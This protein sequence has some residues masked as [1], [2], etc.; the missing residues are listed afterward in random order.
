MSL[1]PSL[2]THPDVIHKKV[3]T[4]PDML[5]M[6]VQ[7]YPDH[8]AVS[9][10][11][12]DISYHCLWQEIEKLAA[13][14]QR[15]GVGK[16]TKIAIMLPNCPAYLRFYFATLLLGG[17]VINLNPLYTAH[18]IAEHISLVE[19]DHI[20]T[21]DLNKLVEK[22]LPLRGRHNVKKIFVAS[23]ADDLPFIKKWGFKATQFRQ[24][25]HQTERD[26]VRYADLV[27]D[28]PDKPIDV[29]PIDPYQDVAV[30][31]LTGGTTGR[32]KASMLTHHNLVSNA[33]QCKA[34]FHGAE[35]GKESF[36]AVIPFFH[37]FAL[38]AILHL[39]ISIGATLIPLPRFEL[40]QLLRTIHKTRPTIFQAVPTIY[41]AINNAKKLENYD[42][43]SIKLCVSGGAPLPLEVRQ[44]FERITGCKLVE[45]YGLTECSPVACCNPTDGRAV[46][47]KSIGLPLP[48]THVDIISLDDHE[49]IMPQGE[50][51]EIHIRGPQ[52]MKGYY[53]QPE[54]TAKILKEG[55]LATGDVGYIDADGYVFIVD[56][57][58]DLI[59]CGGYN[60]YP[61]QVE[62]AVYKH[63]AVEE[64]ICAGIPDIYR[65]E[66]IK[67]WVKCKEGQTVSKEE[68]KT[69]LATF[70]SPI[71]MPKHI[72]FRDNPLPKTLIGKLSRKDILAEE[73]LKT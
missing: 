38:T 21:L 61:S 37:V 28:A 19:A 64:C 7:R 65:G 23:L 55:R 11:G 69:F 9:F 32:S 3:S 34:W 62:S 70:L 58:K 4:L 41:T 66:S 8:V 53:N 60:V 29:A 72:E 6:S 56:R 45:G 52:V 36:L 22:L 31:Q 26:V 67:I 51:G 46:K 50:T 16:G 12:K 30:L 2:V 40:K 39:G 59:I 24:M 48:D 47:D 13:A 27:S 68:L 33:L 1:S 44:N 54:E 5:A 20:V 15:E 18:E 17:T 43:R 71:E 25:Y 63:P 10:L 35:E 73:R 49:T 57:I 42:L 14:L